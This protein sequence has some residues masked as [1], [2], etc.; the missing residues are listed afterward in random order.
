[1][2]KTYQWLEVDVP[3]SRSATELSADRNEDTT[4]YRRIARSPGIETKERSRPEQRNAKGK[5][6]ANDCIERKNKGASAGLSVAV[7]E[8]IIVKARECTVP[9]ATIPKRLATDF[10]TR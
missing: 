6:R 5:L 1:M 8:T 9:S 3:Y 4:G 10:V 2:L 7:I